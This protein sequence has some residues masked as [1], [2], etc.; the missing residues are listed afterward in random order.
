MKKRKKID[1]PAFNVALGKTL[2]AAAWSDGD[3]NRKEMNC[4]QSIILQLPYITFEDWRRL[5]IYLAYPITEP[6]Q[7]AIVEDFIDKVYHKGHSSVA[8]QAIVEILR[9]DGEV[10]KDEI[11]FAKEME[12]A[13]EKN[14]ASFLRKL[15]FFFL[16]NSIKN[17]NA[18]N[19]KKEGRDRFIHEFFENPIYFLF[20]KAIL[21]ENIEIFLNKPE[22]QKICLLAAILCYVANEDGKIDLCEIE[23]IHGLLVSEIG[24]SPEL[25]HLIIRIATKIDINEFKLR[26]LCSSLSDSAKEEETLTYFSFISRLVVFDHEITVK[27]LEI[28]RTVALYLNI[29]K[30]IWNTT[31]LNTKKVEE[32]GRKK[33]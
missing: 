8:W 11:K 29:S 22:L 23:C 32:A 6:E 5:K 10:N 18:W 24:I 7:D 9:A 3:L 16:S 4:L 21:E 33:D 25:A 20:R 30:S 31:L 14:D 28:L 1:Y 13:L 2:A 26:E 27:E 15:K 12:Q 19:T 17:Q